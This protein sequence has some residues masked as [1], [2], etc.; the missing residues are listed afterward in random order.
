[1]GPGFVAFGVLALIG[2]AASSSKP[3]A[4]GN[5]V[6]GS[7]Y[8]PPS[9]GSSGPNKWSI[10][11]CDP[12]HSPSGTGPIQPGTQSHADYQWC[13]VIREDDSPGDVAAGVLGPEQAWRYVELLTANPEMKTKGSIVAPDAG[14]AEMNFADGEWTPGHTVRMP[15][16]WNPWIDQTGAPR[17]ERAPYMVPGYGYGA[18]A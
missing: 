7:G 3:K 17:G 13:Y 1:M 9:N 18:A 8:K 5:T 4:I 2:L 6:G 11:G 10:L 12:F 14:D 15:R 16:T